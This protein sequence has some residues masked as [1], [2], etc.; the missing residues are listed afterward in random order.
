MAFESNLKLQ[1]WDSGFLIKSLRKTAFSFVASIDCSSRDFP[2]NSSVDT[3]DATLKDGTLLTQEWV[4]NYI[5]RLNTDYTRAYNLTREIENLAKV[6][7][8]CT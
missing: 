3:W 1:S 2:E 8:F 5:T 7:L 6:S 4:R